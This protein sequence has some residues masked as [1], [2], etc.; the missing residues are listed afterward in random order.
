MRLER[1]TINKRIDQI[2]VILNLQVFYRHSSYTRSR[3][4]VY[5]VIRNPHYPEKAVV[6]NAGVEVMVLRRGIRLIRE[7][8]QSY[9]GKRSMTMFSVRRYV[10]ALHKAKVGLECE[11]GS[12]VGLRIPAGT[13]AIDDRVAEVAIEVENGRSVAVRGIED[14]RGSDM[15]LP[16]HSRN[17]EE[18]GHRLREVAWNGSV[19]SCPVPRAQKGGRGASRLNEVTP[20]KRTVPEMSVAGMAPRYV[21]PLETRQHLVIDTRLIRAGL[22]ADHISL[23]FSGVIR[24]SV[25]SLSR[26][27]VGTPGRLLVYTRR[28]SFA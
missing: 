3:V 11:A 19:C 4:D 12:R 18:C 15:E 20:G 2:V 9:K 8:V 21:K 24:N 1:R 16:W 13:G 10:G 27:A 17:G 14:I 26:T 6:G 23:L 25:K 28:N 22:S 7:E 5:R